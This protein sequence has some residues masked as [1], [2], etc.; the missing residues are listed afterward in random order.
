M[1]NDEEQWNRIGHIDHR[2]NLINKKINFNRWGAEESR[3]HLDHCCFTVKKVRLLFLFT[4]LLLSL[5]F[6]FILGRVLNLQFWHRFVVR[7]F[8]CIDS[9]AARL[10]QTQVC[11]FV[12]FFSFLQRNKSSA[13][14]KC[15]KWM[16]KLV[17]FDALASG[18]VIATD[19]NY[20]GY[21]WGQGISKVN[22]SRC[23]IWMISY[24]SFVLSKPL[25][26]RLISEVF[27]LD[28]I[29]WRVTHC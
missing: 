29:L 25:D 16:R 1:L 23:C 12:L 19:W 5:S 15:R 3:R 21:C 14:T 22:R 8:S 28:Q 24:C 26:F 6:F 17:L 9:F 11:F 27:L 18:T 20:I 4:N 10:F 2:A 13:I 7:W